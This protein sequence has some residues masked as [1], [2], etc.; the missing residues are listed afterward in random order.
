MQDK[1]VATGAQDEALP[2]DPCVLRWHLGRSQ[3]LQSWPLWTPPTAQAGGRSPGCAPYLGGRFGRLGGW[4][5][6]GSWLGR[7]AY[8]QIKA[9]HPAKA[10]FR[11]GRVGDVQSHDG[12]C[13]RRIL[14]SKARVGAWCLPGTR[15]VARTCGSRDATPQGE[16]LRL[17]ALAGP[18][19]HPSPGA[20][21]RRVPRH[22]CACTRKLWFI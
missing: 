13:T 5:R 7:W 10:E 22:R 21:W 3:R 19:A 16:T 15:R 2:S 14:A 6:A 18:G 20:P 11:A 8:L 9:G 4:G 1:G 17:S 12:P